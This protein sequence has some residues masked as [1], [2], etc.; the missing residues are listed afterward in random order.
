MTIKEAFEKH[1]NIVIDYVFVNQ[2]SECFKMFEEVDEEYSFDGDI[3]YF[4]G[5]WNREYGVMELDDE[6]EEVE[7]SHYRF[8]RDNTHQ[9]ELCKECE[10]KGHWS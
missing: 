6:V 8:V 1:K 4:E 10:N 9:K 2:C 3:E 7:E 5:E